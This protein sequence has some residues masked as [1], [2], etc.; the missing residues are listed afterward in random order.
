MKES[1]NIFEGCVET[2][3]LAHKAIADLERFLDLFTAIDPTACD[4]AR[5][6]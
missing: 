2:L 1:A 6:V 3:D 4:Q 5:A